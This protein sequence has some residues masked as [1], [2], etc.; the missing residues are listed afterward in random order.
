M[1]YESDNDEEPAFLDPTAEGIGRV[2]EIGEGDAPMDD[3]GARACA[4]LVSFPHAAISPETIR[5]SQACAQ[6]KYPDHI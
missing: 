2:T 4:L 6:R 1:N 5:T 3:D